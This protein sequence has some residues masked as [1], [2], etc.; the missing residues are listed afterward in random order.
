MKKRY[1][2]SVLFL[3]MGAAILMYQNCS[4]YV[5]QDAQKPHMIINGGN[6]YTKETTVS[7]E[8]VNFREDHI[9]SYKVAQESEV[10]VFAN[11]TWKTFNKTATAEISGK[12]GVKTVLARLKK[13]DGGIIELRGQI[14]YD[15]QPP[16]VDATGILQNGL[17]GLKVSRGDQVSIDWSAQ[18]IPKDGYESGMGSVR[19]FWTTNDQCSTEE[20][21]VLDSHPYISTT[22]ITWPSLAQ[23]PSMF[24]LKSKIKQAMRPLQ[25]PRLSQ[26][27]GA[28]SLGK[29]FTEM[30][31]MSTAIKY[32]F[33]DH[34]DSSP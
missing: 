30:V 33:I 9:Q 23:T 21:Q 1:S 8:F 12:D 4:K 2:L 14:G 26:V 34:H 17:A 29:L 11:M 7:V 24:V 15:T 10:T 3:V 25:Y 28:L 6:K 20:G 27:F 31:M 5:F 13:T 18:D 16:T 32:V 22:T 19:A